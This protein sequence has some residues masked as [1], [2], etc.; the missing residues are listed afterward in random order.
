MIASLVLRVEISL[1]SIPADFPF[2]L[3]SQNCTALPDYTSLCYGK[4]GQPWLDCGQE[5]GSASTSTIYGHE[6]G[7]GKADVLC[8]Q[9]TESALGTWKLIQRK[10]IGRVEV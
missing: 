3:I 10:A 2:S 9:H 8:R 5:P 7:L 1:R 4:R 6:A